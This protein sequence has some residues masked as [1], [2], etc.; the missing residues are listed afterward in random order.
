MKE[1]L[2]TEIKISKKAKGF[3]LAETIA[4]VFLTAIIS[5]AIT[6]IIVTSTLEKK[7]RII[8]ANFKKDRKLQEF[9][10]VYDSLNN[11]YYSEIDKEALIDAAIAAMMN[12]LND[13]YSTYLDTN[14]SRKLKESLVGR[15]RGIGVTFKNGQIKEVFKESPAAQ[16]GLQK[17]DIFVKIN[18]KSCQGLSDE[19]IKD[20]ISKNQKKVKLVISR[21]NHDI[22]Y[23]ISLAALDVPALTTKL[24]APKIGYIYISSFSNTLYKQFRPAL[25]ELEKNNKIEALIIDLRDNVG[26]YLHAASD[27][28]SIFVPQGKPIYFLEDNDKTQ[29]YND[30]TSEQRDYQIVI[31]TNKN[32]AS[33]SEILAAALKD[34]NHALIVGETTFGKGKVQQTKRLSDGSMIKYTTARWLT[35]QK[36]WIDGIGI[37]PDYEVG[38]KYIYNDQNEIIDFEDLQLQK[39]ISLLS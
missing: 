33:A 18:D 34:N 20:L 23:E 3:N 27:V 4:I 12:Y 37:K 16:A 1:N 24:V 38:L 15:Y 11:E 25:E 30:L 17:D 22:N 13:N 26:G 6:G 35:P 5:A 19:Q 2:Q 31:I 14:E 32:T 21:A 9:F 39:A 8:Y 29:I 7:N 36:K 10:D 28:A